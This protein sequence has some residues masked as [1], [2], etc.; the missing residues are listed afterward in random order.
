MHRSGVDRARWLAEL[1]EALEGARA[2]LAGLAES[3]SKNNNAALADRVDGVIT[4]VEALRRGRNRPIGTTFNPY[5]TKSRRDRHD[6][7][8]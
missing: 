6:Q 3:P 5:W 4:E 1:A 2:I 7:M 8:P